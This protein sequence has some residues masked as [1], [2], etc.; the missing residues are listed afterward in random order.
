VD[1]IATEVRGLQRTEVREVEEFF[2]KGQKG[3]SAMP[4]KRNPITAERLAGLSR[5]LRGN[6]LAGFENIAL[7]HERDITH[8]SVERVIVPDSCILLHYM[9]VRLRDM[10]DRL[11]VYPEAM[12]ENLRKTRGLIY[13]QRVLL[14]LVGKGFTRE[15]AYAIVQ[16]NAMDVWK[17]DND[18]RSLLGADAEVSAALTE[19][20]LDDC[21]DAA[22]FLRH[23]GN[24]YENVLGSE[25]KAKKKAAKKQKAPGAKARR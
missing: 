20:E 25:G 14:A 2:K 19:A 16:R 13:S 15:Q 17:G 12:L 6:A 1:K 9:L 11:L 24:I 7:W 18:F 4:H 22:Y 21:F 23:V 3:S 5:V 8:S 10:L